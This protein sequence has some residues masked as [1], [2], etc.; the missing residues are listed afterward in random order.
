MSAAR[1][2]ALSVP[3]MDVLLNAEIARHLGAFFSLRVSMLPVVAIMLGGLALMDPRPLRL[4]VLS[5]CGLLAL[6]LAIQEQQRF[7]E[8]GL[9]PRLVFTNALK[10]QLLHGLLLLTTGGLF[11]PLLP[12]TVL[13][14]LTASTLM[15]RHPLRFALLPVIALGLLLMT[16]LH[17]SGW[18]TAVSPDWILPSETHLM[19]RVWSLCGVVLFFVVLA[20]VVG[21][22]VRE[23]LERI[24]SQAVAAREDMLRSLEEQARDL[25]ALS[26]EL[27]HELKNPLTSIKGLAGL[28]ALDLKSGK[29]AERLSTLRREV[30][31]MQGILEEFLT[32]SRP[33]VP[34]SLE[35]VALHFLC[36]DVA[37][38]HEGT[39]QNN[40][41]HLKVEGTAQVQGD[42]RKLRQILINLVQNAVEASPAGGLILLRVSESATQGEVQV[43]D[44]GPGIRP[45]WEERIFEAGV[46]TKTRGSGLGLTIARALARQ[47]GG[48]LAL[49][50]APGAGCRARI[51]LP[52]VS[53]AGVDSTERVF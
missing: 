8:H 6:T 25:T 34:L 36:Q 16:G 50:N 9:I 11:S 18:V 31:R 32:F 4:I 1:P 27:A 15:G 19:V 43:E 30:E 44:Q 21:V 26:G 52:R 40:G 38:L 5:A 42:P 51:Q 39:L 23:M 28:L 17:L 41:L 12:M 10:T 47:H 33:L 3:S 53:V 2:S 24:L 22:K 20:S 48:E 29:P 14:T 35:S 46:T 13:V 7:E 45:G 49:E 37:A